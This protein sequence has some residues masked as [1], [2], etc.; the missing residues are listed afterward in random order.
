[1]DGY[2]AD[3]LINALGSLASSLSKLLAAAERIADSMDR[4]ADKVE[5]WAEQDSESEKDHLSAS[6]LG[7]LDDVTPDEAEPVQRTI[8]VQYAL[9]NSIAR[10]AEK[11]G[12]SWADAWRYFERMGFDMSKA[13]PQYE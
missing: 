10:H 8:P 7:K 4:M 12:I 11:Q 3:R 2:N 5:A 9:N 1:M 13:S 6:G